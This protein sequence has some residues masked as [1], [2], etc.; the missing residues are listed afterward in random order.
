MSKDRS[1]EANMPIKEYKEKRNFDKTPEPEGKIL[2][3]TKNNIFIIQKHQARNLHW[4]LRLERNGVLKSWAIPKEPSTDIGVKRLAINV[5]DHP[6]EYAA[7]EGIIP[8]GEYGAGTVEIW[9]KGSYELMKW[10]EREI[11]V[12]I[13]GTKLKGEYVLIKTDY[14]QRKNS[15]LFFKKKK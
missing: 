1:N 2:Q 3:T 14:G 15:W 9:D 4:D 5:E 11:I 8:Q 6:I 7:F 13:L 10:E 12:N